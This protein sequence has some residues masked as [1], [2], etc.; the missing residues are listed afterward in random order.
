M[1]TWGIDFTPLRQSAE[2][3]RLYIAGAVTALGAQATYVTMPYQLKLLTHSPLQVGA[4]GLAE[5]VPLIV[6]GLYGG[7]LA[8]RMNRRRLIIVTEAL[9]MITT[10]MILLNALQHHPSVLVIYATAF[11]SA[12]VGSL[13]RP[14]I[15]ALNQ[16]FV[17]HDLQRSASTLQMVSGTIASIIGP[18]TGGL[19]AVAFGPQ[20]VYGANLVTFAAS[21][22]LLTQLRQQAAPTA[23]VE[24]DR[25]AFRAALGRD[26]RCSR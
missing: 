16:A 13:Q 8:D 14:S 19:V 4:L 15:A 20:F 17:P 25:A 2:Y 9:L 6:F 10:A 21:L 5:V 3:R 11:V 23:A 18:V 26:L 7:V 24:S 12:A 1:S 22:V